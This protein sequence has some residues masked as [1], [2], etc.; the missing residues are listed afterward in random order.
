MRILASVVSLRQRVFRRRTTDPLFDPGQ[1]TA[2]ARV[3]DQGAG[4]AIGRGKERQNMPFLTCL[5]PKIGQVGQAALGAVSRDKK[6]ATSRGA[7]EAPVLDVDHC[8]AR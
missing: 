2:V 6:A 5:S 3:R 8:L 1:S 4:G 7:T